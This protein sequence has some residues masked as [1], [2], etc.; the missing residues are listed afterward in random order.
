MAMLHALDWLNPK[1]RSDRRAIQAWLDGA[2]R[3]TLVPVPHRRRW[4]QEVDYLADSYS[5]NDLVP[6]NWS[7]QQLPGRGAEAWVWTD[8]DAGYLIA[9]Y[10]QTRIE[11]SLADAFYAPVTFRF[12]TYGVAPDGMAALYLREYAR[13]G[14]VV[15][16]VRIAVNNLAG[17]PS[18]VFGVFG[19]GFF[20]YVLGGSIDA[21]FYRE[22]LPTRRQ[23]W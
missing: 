23:T 14:V 21:L 3:T 18:I 1:D 13:E 22:R 9:K 20:V 4:G 19:L 15:R 10:D 12:R 11:F 2:D 6:G 16:V 17:V 7:G 5:M 8:G